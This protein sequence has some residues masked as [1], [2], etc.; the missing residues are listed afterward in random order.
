MFMNQELDMDQIFSILKKHLH[1][2]VK[3]GR[4][5]QITPIILMDL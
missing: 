5:A 1:L 3:T 2:T 4:D